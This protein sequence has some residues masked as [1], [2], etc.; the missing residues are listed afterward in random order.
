MAGQPCRLLNRPGSK[1]RLN[2]IDEGRLI[3]FCF[4][5]RNPFVIGGAFDHRR[6]LMSK[7]PMA[8]NFKL[9]RINPMI[10]RKSF[11]HRLKHHPEMFATPGGS[12]QFNASDPIRKI[13]SF[14][15]NA[16]DASS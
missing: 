16:E 15:P 7:A 9:D 11:D 10:K 13:R 5:N 14:D 4:P 8:R 1:T 6:G 12:A 2:E 3:G